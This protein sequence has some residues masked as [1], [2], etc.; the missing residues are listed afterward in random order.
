M[1]RLGEYL[2]ATPMVVG[3]RTRNE[4]LKPGVVYFRHGAS[5]DSTGTPCRK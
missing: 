5:G 1:R 4:D 2:N 3:L